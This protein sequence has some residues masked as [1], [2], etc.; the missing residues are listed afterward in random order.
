MKKIT[1]KPKIFAKT[2]WKSLTNP[3]YYKD[4]LEA[5]KSFS[6]KYLFSLFFVTSLIV[7]I[8]ISVRML[9]VVPQTPKFVETVK[10]FLVETYPK[11]LKLTLKEN[12]IT[13]NVKEPYFIN[14]KEE[15]KAAIAPFEHLVVIDTKAS[16]EKIQE[17][18]SLFLVNSENLVIS[19]GSV[20]GSYKVVP[21]NETLAKI[22][23]GVSMDK[24][25]FT[26]ILEK[27]SPYFLKILPRIIIG[28]S[29]AILLLYAPLRGGISFLV[30]ILILLPLS[31]ILFLAAK[32][33]KKKIT[34]SKTYQMSLHGA[35]IPVTLSFLFGFTGLYP[36]MMLISWLAFFIFMFVVVSKLDKS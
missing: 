7:G 10:T 5:K 3:S 22:P 20:S 19:D 36:Y 29:I 11:E 34:F 21:L 6:F 33:L 24:T 35:T 18:N 28:I 25:L 17:L 8:T 4:I 16:P 15:Q 2:F 1:S 12:K 23:N 13:T 26:S 14:L 32:V 30:E 27:M 9:R 31:L